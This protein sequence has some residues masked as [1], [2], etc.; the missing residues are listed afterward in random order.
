M[1]TTNSS[2]TARA[3]G[4]SIAR[5]G[6]STRKIHGAGVSNLG[7]SASKC[8]G[9]FLLAFAFANAFAQAYPNKP[10]RVVVPVAAGG[11]VDYMARL[12]G[13]KLSIALGQQVVVENRVGASGRI[14]TAFVARSA[15]DG[16]TLL[17][18]Y[19]AVIIMAPALSPKLPYDALNDFSYI[20]LLASATYVLVVH[21]SVPVKSVRELIGLAKSAPGR[22]NYASSGVAGP[23][24]LAAELMNLIA[25]VN[26]AHIPYKGSAPATIAVIS[27]ETDMLF[28]NILPAV[29]AIKD[30]RLKPLAITSSKRSALLPDVPTV[31]EA[32]FP[33]GE[34]ETLYGLLGPA[35]IPGDILKRLYEEVVK[36]MQSPEMEGQ[37]QKNDFK[38]LT[39]TPEEFRKTVSFETSKWEKVIK[40]RG[41]KGD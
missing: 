15:P 33:D 3:A 17:L 38:P 25:G 7:R 28:S 27:G 9:A 40:A 23:P 18:G 29:P 35:G 16:Y 13:Q 21:P 4:L 10:I 31:S 34:V 36:I 1:N 8:V 32:G 37:L 19:S 24:H 14:G 22:L 11:G 41:I 5:T 2:F 12:V 20:S 30:K 39:S 6:N 26:I